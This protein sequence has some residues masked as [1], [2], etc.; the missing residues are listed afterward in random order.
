[1]NNVANLVTSSPDKTLLACTRWVSRKNVTGNFL[2]E[3]L[4]LLLIVTLIAESDY[5]SI[6]K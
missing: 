3:D 6:N 2:H 5:V 4:R 1:M